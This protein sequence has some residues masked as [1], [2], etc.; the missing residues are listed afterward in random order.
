MKPTLVASLLPCGSR[1]GRSSGLGPTKT[2]RLSWG[3]VQRA[4]GRIRAFVILSTRRKRLRIGSGRTSNQVVRSFTPMRRLRMRESIGTTFI[5]TL[6]ITRTS[7]FAEDSYEQHRG[8]G[9]CSSGRLKGR[10]LLLGRGIPG[11]RRGASF[12]IQRT[13]GRRRSALR[14]SGQR[15]GRKRLT[16]LELI[17]KA[18]E[19]TTIEDRVNS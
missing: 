4:K 19:A 6:L 8:L 15:G 12:P 9:R 16:Y 17:G 3:I 11:I 10:T 14:Q 7:M 13:Q 18:K 1:M 5:I 2:R